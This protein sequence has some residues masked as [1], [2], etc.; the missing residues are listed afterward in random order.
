MAKKKNVAKKESVKKP[1]AT[2]TKAQI[3]D[4]FVEGRQRQEGFMVIVRNGDRV[5]PVYAQSPAGVLRYREG[6]MKSDGT[7]PA[8]TV[9]VEVYDLIKVEMKKQ[10]AAGGVS[11]DTF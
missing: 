10:V 3:Q 5:Y 4:W 6:V 2:A 9:I 8:G 1:V 7:L 11:V